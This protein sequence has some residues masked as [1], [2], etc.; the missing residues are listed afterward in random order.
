L[1]PKGSI[2]N[3]VLKSLY[4]DDLLTAING[5]ELLS[6]AKGLVMI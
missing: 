2:R 6:K 5:I 4:V 3:F 1:I